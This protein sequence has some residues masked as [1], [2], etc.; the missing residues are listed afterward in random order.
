MDESFSPGGEQGAWADEEEII[1]HLIPQLV[2]LLDSGGAS[3]VTVRP[4]S[5]EYTINQ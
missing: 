1:R 5:Q 4:N 2:R 3:D